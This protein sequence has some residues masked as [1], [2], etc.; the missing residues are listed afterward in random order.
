MSKHFEDKK[1]VLREKAAKRISK[2]DVDIDDLSRDQLKSLI[3]DYQLYQVELEIQNEELRDAQNKLQLT[4]DRFAKL[5]NE[6][7]FGYVTIDPNGIIIQTN[8]TF[9]DMAGKAPD[10]IS[11]KAMADVIAPED[12]SSFHGRFRA[13]FKNPYNKQMDFRL[14]RK[15]ETLWVRCTAR[16]E[17]DTQHCP[18]DGQTYLLMA[19]ND[20]SKQIL[21]E[22]QLQESEEMFK[23]LF[24]ESP[25][26]I[27][28]HD[29]NSGEIIDANPAVFSTY[30]YSDIQEL[31]SR[32]LWIDSPY[33]FEQALVKIH[34]AASEGPQK[35]EW[36]NRKKNGDLLWVYVRLNSI[37]INGTKRV[38]ATCADI[39][40]RKKAEHEIKLINQKLEQANDQKDK[41][42]SIIAHDLKS[43][44]SG[45]FSISKLLAS[46]IQSLTQKEIE[47]ISNEIHKSMENSMIL[48]DDLLQWAQ[49]SSSGMEFSPER[50]DIGKLI[51]LALH[52]AMDMAERKHIKIRS[53]V[54][55]GLSIVTDKYMLNTVFRN[56]IFNAIKF[57]PKEGKVFIRVQKAESFV[58][59]CIQDDGIGMS[60]KVLS[61]IF[62]V[63]KNKR[64]LGTEGEKGTGLG[65]IL[66]KNFVEK[67]GGKIWIESELNK[68]TKVFFTL[69]LNP[70]H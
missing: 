33:S 21:A 65:L 48:L 14:N 31:R 24:K 27:F 28:I 20:V 52:T 42:L 47:T 54:P 43:P 41:L 39:T 49:M 13:F 29:R 57:T 50:I 61:S 15:Q 36:L 1:R 7:P 3:E 5:Y 22:R 37:T 59:V 11:G 58:E 67:H 53:E 35:F 32:R 62:T 34:K 60:E 16:I 18:F 8:Q 69:P 64:Q 68:G 70:V 51:D 2:P 23:T 66:C 19:V 45:V 46:D 40:H 55:E 38:L 26:A 25:L 10:Q 63:D 17:V 44:M 30:G 9:A 56:L 6:A 4:R 12:R